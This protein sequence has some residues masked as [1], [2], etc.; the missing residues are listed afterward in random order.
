[1]QFTKDQV[2][3]I[4]SEIDEAI[5][6][7]AKKHGI[8]SQM[9]NAKFDAGK[10]WLKVEFSNDERERQEYDLAIRHGK[11]IGLDVS[12]TSIGKLL[13]LVRYDHK[14]NARPWVMKDLDGTLYT[15]AQRDMEQR[16]SPLKTKTEA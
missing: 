15:L 12:K 2:Q 9:G 16:C 4:L 7:V 3:S 11:L 6:A 13:M 14:R 1:M 5:A 10:F 8:K